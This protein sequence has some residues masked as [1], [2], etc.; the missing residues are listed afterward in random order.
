MTLKNVDLNNEDHQSRL[1][2]VGQIAAGI[3]HEVRNPLTA[4][5]GFLQLLNEQ[6]PHHYI[7]IAQQELDNAIFTL[8]NLLNV[9]KPDLED[10]H[11]VKIN[12]CDEMEALLSLFQD[13]MYRVAILKDF[14]QPQVQ[15]IGKKNQLKRAFFNI[16]K[17]AFEAIEGK[18]AI[19]ISHFVKDSTVCLSVKDS[20]CG[21]PKDKLMLLGTPFYTTKTDGTGM[22]LAYV[23]STI[24]QNS[25]KMNIDSI[26]NEGTT[27]T[28]Q[29]PL[30]IFNKKGALEMS[31]SYE[32]DFLLKDFITNNRDSFEQLLIHEAN[33]ISGIIQDIKTI[34]NIDLISNAHKLVEL[35]VDNSDLEIV[36]FAQQEGRLWANH[37]T[38]N[39][40]V[41]LEWFQAIRRALWSFIYSY[42]Q[43]S[44][45]EHSSEHFFALEMRIN[46]SLDNFLRHFFMSYTKL[47][48]ELISSHLEMINDLSVPI[49][50]LTS[51]ISILPLL[52]TI[53]TY[54][55]G[56]IQD[57]VL[58]QIGAHKIRTLLID[59]SGVELKDP[60]IV[61]GLF[62]IFEGVGY[63]GCRT[64]ITGIR[65]ETASAIVSMDITPL[66]NVQTKGTLQQAL[67]E[68]GIQVLSPA[69]L[70]E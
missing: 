11:P 65:P 60:A 37:S 42:E 62:K 35:L 30:N 9:S 66:G 36:H 49:I 54:R 64:I 55:T 6:A 25:G 29:F 4:V 45:Q 24:Y 70:A 48:D 46:T 68:L 7:D 52:G 15:I 18:G 19:T 47:K 56:I 50:P 5:K 12:L 61:K 63:M 38:L 31:L 59:M 27:F 67:E 13:Q 34:G 44:G 23:F 22:G 51:T 32:K 69:Q 57:K 8:Q 21:I 14:Q 53:D 16:L 3:A 28:F 33:N 2:S 43:H 39:V 41:K 1:A 40:A 20:G 17:N 10:E 26:E 58:Q